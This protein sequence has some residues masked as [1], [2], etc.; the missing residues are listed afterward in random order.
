MSLILYILE[1]ENSKFYVGV[2]EDIR[3][4]L[5]EHKEGKGASWT[6]KHKP[7]RL[8]WT[9]PDASHA[10]EELYTLKMMKYY[11]ICNVRGSLFSSPQLSPQSIEFI[12]EKINNMS[13]SCFKCGARNHFRREC[14]RIGLDMCVRCG[15]AGHDAVNC[16]ADTDQLGNRIGDTSDEE[17]DLLSVADYVEREYDTSDDERNPRSLVRQA[18]AA[19]LCTRCGRTTH[20][21]DKCY[22]RTDAHRRPLPSNIR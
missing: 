11:G 13:N 1:L 12:S 17:D 10:D 19:A 6:A 3:R 15:R 20:T 9:L 5:T 18:S 16:V 22:A 21:A 7:I 8:F 14:D 4:R 2:T